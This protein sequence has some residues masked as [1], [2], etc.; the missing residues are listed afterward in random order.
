MDDM[1]KNNDNM[2]KTNEEKIEELFKEIDS[3]IAKPEGEQD[4]DLIQRCSDEVKALMSD[5]EKE[6]EE[7]LHAQ[8]AVIKAIAK[9]HKAPSE[10][11]KKPRRKYV[12]L[13]VAAVLCAVLVTVFVTLSVIASNKGYS[14]A[15]EYISDKVQ[16]FLG[17][18]CGE[19][20]SVGE[21]TFVRNGDTTKYS[22][23]EEM[24]TKEKLDI[25]YPSKLP[26]GV[27]IEQV[28]IVEESETQYVVYI[29]TSDNNISMSIPIL[30]KKR[31]FF[32]Y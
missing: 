27:K 9:E 18:K 13:K 1:K 10:A 21:I 2:N 30:A 7:E 23:I 26:E 24:L 3:E 32:A 22:D 15:C 4:L 29:S 31:S 17:M 11:E 20:S 14:S 6:S 16:T 28:R 5:D 8:L 12:P 25:L 19:D